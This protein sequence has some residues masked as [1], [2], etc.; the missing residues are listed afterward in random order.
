MKKLIT[1]IITLS[2]IFTLVLPVSAFAEDATVYVSSTG[3]GSL[4]LRSGPGKEYSVKGYVYHNSEVTEISVSGEWSKVKVSATGK[5]GWIKTRY[6]DG[7]TADLGDGTKT[8]SCSSSL[9][10]RS[11]P[12][13]NYSVKGTVKN[14]TTV[15]VLN[16]E[17]NWVKITDYSTGKT[18]WIMEKYIETESGWPSFDDVFGEPETQSVYHVTT[19]TLNVRSG[20]GSSYSK[21]DTLFEGTAFKVLD[22]S[23]NWLKIKTFDGTSGWVSKNYVA[24]TADAVIT[25]SKL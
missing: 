14:G 21:V 13:T 11:G 22:T 2:L 4:N 15:K 17:D 23:G 3:K 12:G 24:A 1:V 10:L 5:T 16:T 8:V 6:I 9:N 20:A 7:T 19:S 25:A 18:G